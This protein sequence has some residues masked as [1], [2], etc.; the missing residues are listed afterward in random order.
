M[1]PRVPDGQENSS[2]EFVRPARAALPRRVR[3]A[4]MVMTIDLIAILV[5]KK[6][7][8]WMRFAL[9]GAKQQF[10]VRSRRFS[11]TF[12]NF[13]P[14]QPFTIKVPFGAPLIE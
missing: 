7:P 13:R 10:S 11:K 14:G 5:K 2:R 8:L 9:R 6:V 12:A 1:D 3:H 4:Q